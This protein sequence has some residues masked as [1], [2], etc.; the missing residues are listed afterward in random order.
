[1]WGQSFSYADRP[2]VFLPVEINEEVGVSQPSTAVTRP[3]I[4][5][6]LLRNVRCLKVPI[7]V[8]LKLLG[9]LVA[10]VEAA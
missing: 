9:Q 2:T 4:L 10:C 6:I 5:E 7:D 3:A 1:M 8:E